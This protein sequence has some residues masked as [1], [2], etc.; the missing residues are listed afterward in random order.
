MVFLKKV[1]NKKI[2]KANFFEK[3]LFSQAY[4]LFD[5]FLGVSI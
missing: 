5:F 4:L 3:K 1:N 2:K